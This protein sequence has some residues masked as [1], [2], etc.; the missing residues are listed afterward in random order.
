MKEFVLPNLNDERSMLKTIRM[1]N[2]TLQKLE[3]LSSKN[4][5]SVNRL[6]NEC[7]EFALENLSE[8]DTKKPV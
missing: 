5:I 7:I 4:D 1:K 2:S 3:E 8:N 6:I